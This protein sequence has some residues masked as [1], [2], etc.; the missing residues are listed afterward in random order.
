MRGGFGAG[1]FLPFFRV[2]S[3]TNSCIIWLGSDEIRTSKLLSEILEFYL[4]AATE[5]EGISGDRYCVYLPLLV[6]EL[7]SGPTAL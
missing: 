1:S 4:T 2:F 6:R 7:Y 5:P 3:I